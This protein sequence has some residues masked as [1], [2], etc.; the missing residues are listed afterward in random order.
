MKRLIRFTHR[1]AL[2]VL[3]SALLALALLV[4]LLRLWLLPEIEGFRSSLETRIG[5]LIGERVRIDGLSARLH[6]FHPEIA[7]QGFHILDPQGRS[8]IRF[9]TVRLNLDSFRTLAAGEP[10]FD[11]VEVI[12]PKLSIRRKP[13]GSLTVLGLTLTEKPPAWLLAGR[14]IDLLDADVDW[15]DQRSAAP[16]LHL[17]RVDL[18]LRNKGGRHR[19]GADFALPADLGRSLRLAF[20]A[21]G[22]LF[23]ASGW[24]G[25]LYLE[26]R[27]LD[28]G[29]FSEGLPPSAFGLRA[30]RADA[31]VWM[32]WQGDVRSVAGEF[33]VRAPLFTHRPDSGAEHRLALKSLA[34]RFRWEPRDHGWRLD[35]GQFRPEFDRAWP[36]TRLAVAVTRRADGGLESVAAA[37]THLDLADL[38]AV[39]RALPLLGGK[40]GAPLRSLAPKGTLENLR[41]FYAPTEHLGRR[42]A[43]CGRFRGV[44][45]RNRGSIPGFSGLNGTLCGTDGAGSATL[46]A[47]PGD[48]DLAD[49]G[50]KQPVP[51][52]ELKASLAWR[53][54]ESGWKLDIP[55]LSGRNPELSLAGRA[56]IHVPNRPD[57]SPF[58]DLRTRISGMEVAAVRHYLPTVLIPNTAQWVEQALTQGR[59]SRWDILFHGRTADFPFDKGEGVF[60]AELDAANVTMRYS[61]DWPALTEA[62]LHAAFRGPGAEIEAFRGRIGAGQ[63]LT[64]HATIPDMVKTPWLALTGSVRS[65]VAETLDFLAHSPLR[66]IPE[67]L[68][69]VASVSGDADIALNLRVPLNPH[70]GE[71][72]VEGTADLRD[73]ALHLD[74]PDLPVEKLEGPLRFSGEGLRAEALHARI[75]GE[76]ALIDVDHEADEILLTVRGRAETAA[77]RKQFPVAAWSHASGGADYRLDLRLPETLDAHG[78]PVT[79]AL[80]S[81][82][83]GLALNLPAPFGK[84]AAG[85][86]ALAVEASVKAGSG[87]SLRLAYGP[88]LRARLRFGDSEHGSRL[89]D[90]DIAIGQPL[91]VSGRGSGLTLAARLDAL[92]A[93][94][95]WRWGKGLAAEGAGAGLLREWQL[96]IGKLVWNGTDRGRFALDLKQDA[97]TWQGRID[98]AFA[99]GT[100]SATS[101]LARFELD[102]LEIPRLPDPPA[103]ENKAK[104]APSA[105]DTPEVDP[106]TLPGFRVR[107]RH[108]L[109]KG[110]DLGPL[111]LDTERRAH[112]MIIRNLT[113]RAGTH[114]LNLH[115][116]WTR[117]PARAASTH[118]EG[119]LHMDSL[120]EFLAVLGRRGEVRDTASD[121]AFSLDWPGAP[122][123]FS[124]G[125]VA[126]EVKLNL[127]KGALLNI[128]PGLG[129]V[130]GMLNLNSL[131]RRLSLDFSDLFGKGLAYDG[132][133]GTFRIG[134]GQAVTEAFLIDAVSAKI[135]TTGRAGLVARDLDQIVTVIPHTTAALPIAGALAGGPAVGAALYVAQQL[136]GEEVDRLTA[137]QY[138]VK[139]GWNNPEITRINQNLP[140]DML[141]K[142]WSGVKNLS[143]FGKQEEQQQ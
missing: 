111:E 50:V 112:G 98:S 47:A 30:G 85:S 66:R 27:N 54:T 1:A 28:V 23:E 89:E 19:L 105:A 120:G 6:G 57:A 142:A 80:D 45:V 64:A 38:G 84:P 39:L 61:P 44:A 21:E 113:V 100:I 51:F 121:L 40:T 129:R 136:V 53:Q 110:A 25:T 127:G 16:P 107:S 9:A 18:R 52:T 133:A 108:T 81:D 130:V 126:G 91:P 93:G 26:G 41:G 11:R 117:T 17:N 109:W 90:G 3:C 140:L 58:L 8:A 132:I 37:A 71:P 68:N 31:K 101:E 77:L 102:S 88:D 12:G 69:R 131:W 75:L 116:H 97:G 63:V 82:L 48:L 49:L 46:S 5:S 95:W 86:R 62:D 122:Y 143:G 73:A 138:A 14:R 124:A 10:R 94:E 22:D 59:I 103:A 24:R 4:S 55:A 67:R 96:H 128:E 74:A 13:D 79:L 125:T 114:S 115:G 60:E 87:I 106:A 123:R 78:A 72:H 70:L 135:L 76:P 36:D 20:D 34:G 134:E 35:L 2:H 42:W 137:T 7:I 33:D 56:R 139:S 119:T 92:D 32:R 118:L 29:R 141:D 65:R 43:L 99:R 15:Q 83:A 104:A